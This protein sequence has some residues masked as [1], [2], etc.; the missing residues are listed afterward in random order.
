MEVTLQKVTGAFL[1]KVGPF[2]KSIKKQ[3]SP[4][5]STKDG[6]FSMGNG[7]LVSSKHYTYIYV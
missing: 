6:D 5:F 3:K 2:P 1:E 7:S 4:T